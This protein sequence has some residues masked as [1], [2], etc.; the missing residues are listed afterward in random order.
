MEDLRGYNAPDLHVDNS[1]AK[2][3]AGAAIVTLAVGAG[4]AYA[5]STGMWSQPAPQS[6]ALREPLSFKAPA[7]VAQT[8]PPA[9]VPAAPVAP[10]QATMAPT[11][12]ARLH[13]QKRDVTPPVVPDSSPSMPAEP[14]V[15]PQ[16]P[17]AVVP[18][19]EATPPETPATPASPPAQPAP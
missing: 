12:T 14:A 13:V 10:A 11:R 18:A 15:T 4:A 8:P 7:P 3:L 19:P 5:F 2:L 16:S 9:L 1:T 17:D 6:I